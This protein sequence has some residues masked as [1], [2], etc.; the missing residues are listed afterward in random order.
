MKVP[1]NNRHVGSE[2][3]TARMTDIINMNK[4]GSFIGTFFPKSFRI[5][6]AGFGGN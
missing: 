3:I 6:A 2:P 1:T 5:Y 4:Q